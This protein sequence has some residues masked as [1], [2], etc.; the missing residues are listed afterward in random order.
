M[1]QGVRVGNWTFWRDPMETN[2]QVQRGQEPAWKW[3]ELEDSQEA[4]VE[5]LDALEVERANNDRLSEQCADL[6]RR[7]QLMEL[8]S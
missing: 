7:V 1:K 5:L 3:N 6:G 2:V 4:V 8:G